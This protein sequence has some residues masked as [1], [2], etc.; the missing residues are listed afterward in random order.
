M[1]KGEFQHQGEYY[2]FEFLGFKDNVYSFQ[3][4]NGIIYEIKFKPTPY[5]F[6]ETSI[7]APH[8]FEM[9]IEVAIN[10][11]SKN[12]I[13]DSKAS[14]TVASIFEDFYSKSDLHIIIYICESN[15]GRQDIRATKFHKWFQHFAPKNYTK[16]DAAFIDGDEVYP[17]SLILKLNNPDTPAIINNFYAIIASSLSDK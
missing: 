8:S 2:N 9:I 6:G 12:P 4:E 1:R 7:F 17:V 15:D 14:R 3:T 13:F 16:Y 11:T 5:L 10:P